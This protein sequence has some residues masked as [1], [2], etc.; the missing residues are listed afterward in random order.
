MDIVQGALAGLR[1]SSSL[2]LIAVALALSYLVLVAREN[3][4]C[5]FAAAG[6]TLIYLVLFYD[7]GLYAESVLQIYYLG[8]A[9]YGYQQWRRGGQH[10]ILPIQRWSI[11]KHGYALLLMFVSTIVVAQLLIKANSS[12]PY[13]DAFTTCAAVVTTYMVTQK[14]LENW[15]YWFVI[16]TASIVLY[17]QRELYFTALLFVIYLLIIVVG[18]HQWRLE[19]LRLS[20]SSM[21]R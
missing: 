14:I 2:E 6:S 3:I 11:R 9:A 18:Y 17:F 20:Q 19:Y 13:L 12:A 21:T 8:M 15:F 4:A 5:W 1:E 10:Q 16:D 7:V